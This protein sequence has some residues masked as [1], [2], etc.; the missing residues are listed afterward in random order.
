MGRVRKY[1]ALSAAFSFSAAIRSRIATALRSLWFISSS[2]R[3]CSSSRRFLSSASFS[4][5]FFLSAIA[6]WTLVK[7]SEKPGISAGEDF[8]LSA[9]SLAA[10][11]SLAILSLR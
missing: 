6:A 9:D 2:F 10:L 11:F 4:S 7:V 1:S 3:F 5:A 8:D